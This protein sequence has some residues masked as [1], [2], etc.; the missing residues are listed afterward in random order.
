MNFLA[1]QIFIALTY[2]AS[3]SAASAVEAP[4]T[5][6]PLAATAV[7]E[8]EFPPAA[9]ADPMQIFAP[10]LANFVPFAMPALLWVPDFSFD[11]ALSE[12]SL[13]SVLTVRSPT[14]E[15]ANPDYM[16]RHTNT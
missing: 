4:A 11:P 6:V 10:G 12:Q 1:L 2:A 16:Y 14:D 15:E 5:E 13:G 9:A 8:G 3:S 7:A